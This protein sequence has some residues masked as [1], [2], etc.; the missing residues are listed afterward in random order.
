[1][2]WLK[3]RKQKKGIS[4]LEKPAFDWDAWNREFDEHPGDVVELRFHDPRPGDEAEWVGPKPKLQDL[5]D[6]MSTPVPNEGL[7]LGI[8]I[9]P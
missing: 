1:M 4:P 5:D 9:E 7:G 8:D 6:P 2:A 3:L